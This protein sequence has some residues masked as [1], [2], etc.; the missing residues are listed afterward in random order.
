MEKGEPELRTERNLKQEELN[1]KRGGVDK[2]C[3]SSFTSV[4]LLENTEQKGTQ[5][6]GK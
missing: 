3:P 5:K 4:A 1:V 2:E 6:T